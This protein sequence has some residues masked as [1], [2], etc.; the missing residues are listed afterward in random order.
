MNNKY[1]NTQ[2]HKVYYKVMYN[3]CSVI[4]TLQFAVIMKYEVD[5]IESEEGNIMYYIIYIL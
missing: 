1:N 4:Y 5:I 2:Y 3:I